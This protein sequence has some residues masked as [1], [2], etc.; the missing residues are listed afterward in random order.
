MPAGISIAQPVNYLSPRL[1]GDTP[2]GQRRRLRMVES[3]ASMIDG[4]TDSVLKGS[5]HADCRNTL[6]VLIDIA[7]YRKGPEAALRAEQNLLRLYADPSISS[8]VRREMIGQLLEA[9]AVIAS[10]ASSN[11]EHFA[12]PVAL[13][14]L[15]AQYGRM[16]IKNDEPRP[17]VG[18]AAVDDMGNRLA[19]AV[20]V[21][22]G[23]AAIVDTQRFVTGM[24]IQAS[25]AKTECGDSD[26]IDLSDDIDAGAIK[27]KVDA[28]T[29]AAQRNG[30]A[31][32]PLFIA[33]HYMLLIA[34]KD[35]ASGRC[36]LITVDTSRALDKQAALELGRLSAAG[37]VDAGARQRLQWLQRESDE[38]FLLDIS[39]RVNRPL[40]MHCSRLQT[41][42][43]NGCGPLIVLLLKRIDGARLD[44]VAATERYIAQQFDEWRSFDAQ[45]QQNLVMAQRAEMIGDVYEKRNDGHRFIRD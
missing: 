42:V 2:T 3:T 34:K 16:E 23:A 7:T 29:A 45:T 8:A 35:E 26:I 37:H 11:A 1:P 6:E 27:R 40:I 39:N 44:D 30:M 41:N 15:A 9:Q 33:D 28:L 24:E 5:R 22:D 20:S 43:P 21:G 25:F 38:R 17:V 36:A 19:D 10:K 31:V 12:M 14:H 4:L 18:R 32:A 13:L